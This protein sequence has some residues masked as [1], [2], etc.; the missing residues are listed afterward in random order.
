VAW[1]NG[2]PAMRSRQFEL[3]SREAV[4]IGQGNVALDVA[5]VHTLFCWLIAW[6]AFFLNVT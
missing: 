3:S 4:V 6:L 5:R 2:D 1:Y